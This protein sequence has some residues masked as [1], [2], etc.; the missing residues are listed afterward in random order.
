MS[1]LLINP[2]RSAIKE[3]NI[4]KTINRNLPSL[5]LAYIAA[6]L[7]K[8]GI[9]VLICDIDAEGVDFNKLYKKLKDYGVR[10]VGITATTVQINSA[11]YIARKIKEFNS[12]IKIVFGGPHPHILTEE[13]L[14]LSETDFVIRGE[15]EETFWELV[16]GDTLEN[17]RGFSYKENSRLVHNPSRP[18]I[19]DLDSLPFPARHLL[20]M[21]KYR[22]S[23]GRYQRLPATSMIVSRGC[24]GKCTFCYTDVLGHV[25]RFRS[26]KNILAEIEFLIER[27][28]IKEISFYDDTFTARRSMVMELCEML[29]SKDIDLSWSCLSRVDCVD[30]E[31]LRSMRRAGCHMVSYGVESADEYILKNINK[32]ISLEKVKDAVRMTRESGITVQTSFMIGNPGE[33]EKTIKKTLDFVLKLDPHIFVYNIT[34]PFPG[35]EMFNWAKEKGYLTTYNWDDYDLGHIVMKIPTI[36]PELIR[37]YYRYAYRKFYCRPAYIIRYIRKINS[38]DTLKTNIK[39][40]FTMLKSIIFKR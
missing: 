27:Y 2:P 26:P 11:L 37:S 19:A 20:P 1:V 16:R 17:I 3:G 30:K 39:V 12:A 40:F 18:G 8:K 31:L 28:N 24:P 36:S 33:T 7:E 35:T 14:C 21:E 13:T 25:I 15:G 34:T 5:G 32:R 23:A 22:P 38:L 6:Y 29:L 4:W 10:Y 9:K